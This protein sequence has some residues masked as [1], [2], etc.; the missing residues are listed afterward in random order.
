MPVG[1]GWLCMQQCCIVP[2]KHTHT[3]TNSAWF[4]IYVF[5][6]L[7]TASEQSEYGHYNVLLLSVGLLWL[8]HKM[9]QTQSGIIPKC[10]FSKCWLLYAWM[11]PF[12]HHV[13]FHY[14]L[15]SGQ[16]FRYI[17]GT[18]KAWKEGFFELFGYSTF[19]LTVNLL[20]IKLN[21]MKFVT[22]I[23]KFILP[24]LH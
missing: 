4:R 21:I 17:Q 3:Q 5:L 18:Y 13:S 23:Q 10:L 7:E 16:S 12:R 19:C 22:F 1:C 8:G 24:S 2:Q 11:H 15:L 9:I 6:P 14:W 20:C